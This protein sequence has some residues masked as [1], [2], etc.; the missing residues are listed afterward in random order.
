MVES[1]LVGLA[2]LNIHPDIE[3][4]PK[5]IVERFSKSGNHRMVF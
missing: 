4:D 3:L 1:R 5:K 2:L